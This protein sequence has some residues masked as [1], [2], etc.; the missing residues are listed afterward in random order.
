M[1]RNMIGLDISSRRL[2]AAEVSDG[3]LIRAHAV[4]LPEGAARDSEVI[5]VEAVAKSLKRLWSEAGFKTKNVVLGVGNQ[6]VMVRNHTVPVM[7]S[8]KLK[9]ALP[10]QVA[11]LLPVPV[12]ET[13]LDFYPIEEV[14]EAGHLAMRGLLVAAI[15]ENVET[16]AAAVAQAGLRLVGVDLSPFAMARA[17]G[18]AGEAEGTRMIVNI[19]ARTTHLI[20]VREGVPQFVRTLLVGGEHITDAIVEVTRLSRSAAET[21]KYRMGIEE[22][23][24]PEHRAVSEAQLETL[25]GVISAIRS[26]MAFYSENHDGEVEAVSLL[27]ASSHLP[28]L[29]RATTEYSGVP[30]TH[31]KPF[32]GIRI[33]RGVDSDRLGRLAYDFAAP[34][35]L[36][37]GKD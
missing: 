34:V 22:G 17:L 1:P 13:I 27:G 24:N 15:K 37:L 12:N 16:D 6:R 4:E 21:M 11:E 23:R 18:I 7:P 20:V 35:G 8:T 14:E 32:A 33:G 25:R 9:Q 3:T 30:V 10:Y 26:T 5:D 31:A 2:L 19:G 28:G 36:A 29:L